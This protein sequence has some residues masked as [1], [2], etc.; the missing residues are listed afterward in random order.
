MLSPARAVPRGACCDTCFS[1]RFDARALTRLDL[2][3]STAQVKI[4]EFTDSQCR[5]TAV[6]VLTRQLNTCG[7]SQ[8]GRAGLVY[9][10]LKE[11]ATVQQLSC[12]ND[13]RCTGNTQ[14]GNCALN[15]YNP[16]QCIRSSR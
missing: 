8:D 15:N 9:A 2:L 5:G 11:G 6:N 1:L 16:G 3:S 7:R 10:C 12:P 14:R 13:T 4:L